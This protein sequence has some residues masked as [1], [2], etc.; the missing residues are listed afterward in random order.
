MC[1]SS[2]MRCGS[3]NNF[4]LELKGVRRISGLHKNA[5]AAVLRDTENERSRKNKECFLRLAARIV[6][7]IWSSTMLLLLGYSL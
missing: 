3:A 6:S 7:Y 2:E 1:F 5:P 4:L